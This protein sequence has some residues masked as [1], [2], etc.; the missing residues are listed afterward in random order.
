MIHFLSK[1]EDEE[2]KKVLKSKNI[3]EKILLLPDKVNPYGEH[4]REEEGFMARHT[5][6][7]QLGNGDDAQ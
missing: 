6:Q 1:S 2:L 5:E 7:E 3:G 4:R